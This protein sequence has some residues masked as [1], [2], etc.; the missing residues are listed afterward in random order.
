MFDELEGIVHKFRNY[1]LS[2]FL[3]GKDFRVE[4]SIA[5]KILRIS[6]DLKPSLK[7]F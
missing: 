2:K 6:S 5:E 1:R 7:F 4:Y 3:E